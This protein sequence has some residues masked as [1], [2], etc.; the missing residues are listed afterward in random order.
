VSALLLSKPY[1]VIQ[2]IFGLI[3]ILCFVLF[4]FEKDRI[5][6]I[7]NWGGFGGATGGWSISRS[8]GLLILTSLFGTLTVLTGF[9]PWTTKPEDPK[10]SDKQSPLPCTYT[11]SPPCLLAGPAVPSREVSKAQA[12]N[13]TVQTTSK[14]STPSPGTVQS[15]S[16]GAN[17]GLRPSCSAGSETCTVQ[18]IPSS[19]T[20]PQ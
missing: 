5:E 13:S 11:L 12:D 8:L 7:G 20:A 2:V 10:A 19:G 17:P 4:L 14:T 9:G 15:P 18:R 3:T 1:V 16:Y 6:F